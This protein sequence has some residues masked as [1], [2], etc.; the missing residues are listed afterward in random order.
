MR[1]VLATVKNYGGIVCFENCIYASSCANHGTAGDY[2]TESG[3]SPEL[4]VLNRGSVAE[5]VHCGSVDRNPVY[6]QE[7]PQPINYDVLGQGA[8]FVNKN[9]SLASCQNEHSGYNYY[10]Y[11]YYDDYRRNSI[12]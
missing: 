1:K 12:E 10:E 4:S 8:I 7:G 11:E 9:G 5:A 2:R 3:F 6:L